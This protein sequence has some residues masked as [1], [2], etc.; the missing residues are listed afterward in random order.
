MT[1]FHESPDVQGGFGCLLACIGIAIILGTVM[2]FGH[3][4]AIK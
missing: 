2:Y 3:P 1:K 4:V